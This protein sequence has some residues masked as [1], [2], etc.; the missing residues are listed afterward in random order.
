MSAYRDSDDYGTFT[1]AV[2]AVVVRSGRAPLRAE[3]ASMVRQ[4]MRTCQ[5]LGDFDG[6]RRE[7]QI[8]ADANPFQWHVD[9][10]FRKIESAKLST[11]LG[12]RGEF[13][14][15]QK[16]PP[17]TLAAHRQFSGL[18]D[19]VYYRGGDIIA[20]AGHAV[21]S[22]IDVAYFTY[23]PPMRDFGSNITQRPWR[24]DTLTAEWIDQ[25]GNF[26][27]QQD[28]T[29][30]PRANI[31]QDYTTNWMLFNW[32]ELI[33]TGALSDLLNAVNDPRGRQE[34]AKFRALQTDLL[35][36]EVGK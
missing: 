25:R 26:P 21:D 9:T 7:E 19:L 14:Y 28:G 34:F 18:Q 22:V 8:T 2:D 13:L 23:F 16:A 31:P 36:A 10:E 24:Y 6:D 12:P 20:F 27:L 30:D 15:Y 35:K 3:A 29:P 4:T 33:V 1:A 17:G 5:V 11:R 32:F